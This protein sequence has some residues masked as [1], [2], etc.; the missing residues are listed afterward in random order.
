MFMNDFFRG[1]G[2]KWDT[3]L[4]ATDIST[5]VL[6]KAMRG[7]YTS[8]QIKPLD[9]L[10]KKNYLKKYDDG[11]VIVRDEI[12][13]KITY[14]KFNLMENRFPFKKKFHVIF[15]RNV[16]IYFDNETR[17]ALVNRFYEASEDGAYLFIGH[18]ESLN[19]TGTRYQYLQPAVYRK[20]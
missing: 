19:N 20:I 16:M 4:L 10:W 11:N 13:K 14:R 15:C 5:T 8:D 6:T 17:D 7:V 9:E 2:G 1:E 18:S 3:E 12:K